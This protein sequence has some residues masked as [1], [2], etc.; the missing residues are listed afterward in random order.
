METTESMTTVRAQ[1]VP[2]EEI[3]VL[4]EHIWMSVDDHLIDRDSLLVEA[5]HFILDTLEAGVD[6]TITSRQAPTEYVLAH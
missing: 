3:T 4:R 6:I 5:I 2:P 1:D